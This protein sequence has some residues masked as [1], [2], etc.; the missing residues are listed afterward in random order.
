MNRAPVS[1]PKAWPG[2]PA[3]LPCV[4]PP[5]GRARPIFSRRS[6]MPGSIPCPSWPSPA[7]WRSRSS[8]RTPFRRSTPT[9]LPCRLPSIIFSCAIRPS[10]WRSCHWLSSSRS[11]DG[12]APWR[13]TCPRTCKTP[14][15]TSSPGPS[16][17]ARCPFRRVPTSSSTRWCGSS[18]L[19]GTRFSTS[20]A[21]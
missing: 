5:P 16:Q 2:S 9:G 4:W 19:P 8:A 17:A 13:S 20:A 10:C 12:P 18:P 14:R 3:R 1:S 15:P 7:R 21:A 11:P 6:P